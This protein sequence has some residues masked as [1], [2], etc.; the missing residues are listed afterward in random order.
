[1]S[2]QNEL[3]LLE[4]VEKVKNNTL[5]HEMNI[6]ISELYIKYKFQHE[7]ENNGKITEKD[8]MKYCSLGYYIYH[9]L[10]NET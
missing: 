10:I 2:N 1:M 4:L 9:N 5:S 6:A 7:K 3:F 8:L